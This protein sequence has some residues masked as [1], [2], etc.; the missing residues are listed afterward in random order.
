MDIVEP[1]QVYYDFKQEWSAPADECVI[2]ENNMVITQNTV[3]CPGI[4][5]F[6]NGI[7]INEDDIVLDCNNALFNGT[8]G[9]WSSHYIGIYMQYVKNITIRNCQIQNYGYGIAMINSTTNI[10]DHNNISGIGYGIYT[11]RSNN[12]IISDNIID[13][14]ADVGITFS[15]SG[16]SY[17][18]TIKNNIMTNSA[19]LG[20]NFY[21]Y[22][23]TIISNKIMNNKRGI[24]VS[25]QYNN[26]TYNDISNSSDYGLIFWAF[27]LYSHASY[28]NISNNQFGIY[29]LTAVSNNKCRLSNNLVTNNIKGI[30]FSSRSSNNT[31]YE[32]KICKNSE[33]DIFNNNSQNFGADNKCGVAFNWN[34]ADTFSCRY[35]CEGSY[36]ISKGW[37]LFAASISPVDQTTNRTILLNKGWNL[38]G[39]SSES[40]FDWNTALINNKTA[41]KTLINAGNLN[42]IQP[43]IYYFNESVQNYGVVI[44][45]NLTSK[46]GY[47]LYALKDNLT[48]ILPN[49][50][51][52]LQTNS[53][54]WLSAKII[55]GTETKSISDAE[56]FGWL[57][58]TLY[59][60]DKSYKFVPGDDSNVYPWK[61]YWLYSN[62][63]LTLII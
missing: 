55:K 12:T 43:A 59:Y 38:L 19:Y 34:D 6:P 39:Y 40:Y 17:N 36:K 31:L 60:Y 58:S 10:I 23:C 20:I 33:Y 56:S 4:Y 8:S 13:K 28:N 47:W 45:G 57:Q 29:F 16:A 44:F 26:I 15:A 25:G 2:H 18:Y 14:I 53:F 52:S 51:G 50:G 41:T 22:N 7:S 62:Y 1:R 32:N 30:Y 35:S 48:L 11:D 37:N 27:P 9:N 46:K 3:V 42:W 61:G 63:N 54:D 49:V 21:C 24:S 5:N